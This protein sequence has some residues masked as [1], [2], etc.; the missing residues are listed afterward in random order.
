MYIVLTSA[1]DDEVKEAIRVAKENNLT[2]V[3][4]RDGEHSTSDLN[5]LLAFQQAGFDYRLYAFCGKYE[6]DAIGV[7]F[8][9]K[10]K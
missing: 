7:E 9:V 5:V 8:R 10:E 2:V 6:D 3:F 4:R 1:F